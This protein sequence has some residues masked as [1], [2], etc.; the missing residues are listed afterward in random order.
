MREKIRNKIW[1][2]HSGLDILYRCPR[3]F[4]LKYN[5]GI[6]QPEGITSRLPDRFDNVIKIY[7]D[8]F[9]EKGELPPMIKGKMA[10]KLENPF[11][12]RYYCDINEKYGFY[13]KLDECLITPEEK[14]VP[15]DF[16]T[17]SS[18]PRGKDVF[19]SYRN[20]MD[21]FTFLLE[22]HGKKTP[23]FGHLIYFYPDESENLHDGFPM[24]VDIQTIETNPDDVSPRL[25]EAVAVLEDNMPQPADDCPFCKWYDN[26][27]EIFNNQF[28]AVTTEGK[29]KVEELSTKENKMPKSIYSKT[30]RCGNRIYFFDIKEAQSG[31]RYLQITES[32]L[33]EG[34][35]RLRNNIIV[36]KDHFEEF[37]GAIEEIAKEF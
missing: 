24:I 28:I 14:Y 17:A 16:K 11:R 32:R 1:I 13:V 36:F 2:S 29:I 21:E 30:L 12:E 22:F 20:Q 6:N 4:W 35:S 31:N 5:K 18:D 19:L 23:R 26:V 33:Q 15:I 3:C 7:F 9:R 10:G 34:G 27:S 25:L 8:R 37:Q